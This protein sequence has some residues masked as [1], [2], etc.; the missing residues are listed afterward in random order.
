M[1]AIRPDELLDALSPRLRNREH[2]TVALDFTD[3]VGLDRGVTD[4]EKA[5][6]RLVDPQGALLAALGRRDEF[7]FVFHGLVHIPLAA[8]AGFLVSD[9]QGCASTI[10]TQTLA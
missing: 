6:G 8:L 3:L 4:P 10:F 9:R 1:R 5:A 7:E 2:E